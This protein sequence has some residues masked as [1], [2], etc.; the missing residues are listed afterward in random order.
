VKL[1]HFHQKPIFEQLILEEGLLRANPD[2][3]CLINEGSSK[4][5]VMGISSKPSEWVHPSAVEDAIPVIRRFSG[6]GTVVVDQDTLFVTFIFNSDPLPFDPFPEPILRFTETLYQSVFNHPEFKVQGNDYTMGP[7]KCGGNAQY[8]R[9]GRFLH[10]TTFLW[11]YDPL[12]MNYLLHPKKMP[13]YRN[14][15]P[16]TD[17]ICRLSDYF[18]SKKAFIDRL[19]SHLSATFGAE[20]AEIPLFSEGYRTTTQLYGKTELFTP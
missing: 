17:F 5:I 3:W 1:L 10:H 9:K 8:I 12:N 6:G 2:N 18:P 13:A 15:R 19:K 4:A 11:D 16:H 7:R 14:N 20:E